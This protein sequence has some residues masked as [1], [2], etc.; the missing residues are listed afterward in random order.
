MFFCFL[1]IYL[2]ET[3]NPRAIEKSKQGIGKFGLQTPNFKY[4]LPVELNHL[5]R[6]KV[7]YKEFNFSK[8]KFK[9]KEFIITSV[10]FHHLYVLS[11]S[12]K[13]TVKLFEYQC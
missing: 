4:L 12:K 7:N 6:F 1:I 10:A 13:K 9:P 11:Y 5:F 3:Q 2:C 8:E